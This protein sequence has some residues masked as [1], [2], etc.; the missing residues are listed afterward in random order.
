MRCA[1]RSRPLARLYSLAHLT[2]LDCAPP[3]MTYLAARAGYDFVSFRL[4]PLGTPGEP[5]YVPQDLSMLK[6]T[7]KALA[8]TGLKLLDLELA[9]IVDGLD[10]NA[11]L[12]AMEAAAELGAKHVI[13]SAWTT[14]S[15]D[16]NFVIDSFAAICDLAKSLGLSVNFEFPTF[17]RIRD[18]EQAA[19]IVGAA[20]RANGGIL[21][22][23]LYMHFARISP[24]E[25]DLLPP[26]W[27]RLVHLCDAPAAVPATREAQIHIARGARLYAGEGAVDISGILEHLPA[28][29]ISIE[30][31]HLARAAELGN[32]EH[33][34]RCLRS[35]R[36]LIE[37]H[38]LVD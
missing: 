11:Y 29:P 3:E 14:R 15:D 18:L 34:R 26:A 37:G 16:R 20:E 23:M 19:D 17:S 31:P 30:L 13:S 25:L 8:E 1:G 36:R 33:A 38:E 5:K 2:V 21:V 4:I 28:V 9:R 35:A 22:D 7:R 12:P 27:F 6:R 10:A 32:E 24:R